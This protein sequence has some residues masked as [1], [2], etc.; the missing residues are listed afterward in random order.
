[1]G[2]PSINRFTF[3]TRLGGLIGLA[4]MAAA[5]F[6]LTACLDSTSPQQVP[7]PTVENALSVALAITTTK[8]AE[9]AT[10]SGAVKASNQTGFTGTGFADYKNNSS[11]Y[12]RWTVSVDQAGKYSLR[13][14]YANGGAISRPLAIKVNGTTV[15][16]S[17][18]FPATGAWTT[19]S[20]VSL[21]ANLV[22][23]NN[24]VQATAIGSSGANIDYLEVSGPVTSTAWRN[25]VLTWFTSYPDP[26]SEECLEFNGCTWAG[27]FAALDGKQP[28]SWVKAQNIIAVHEKDFSK[29]RLKTFRLKQG[30][31]TIDAKVYD[32]CSDSDCNGCC[33]KNAGSTGFLID[34]EKYTAERFGTREGIVDWT[35]LD[36]N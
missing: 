31:H 27:Q 6:V 33:T 4:A 20:T 11:D 24:T 5:P 32:M 28:E 29:Y 21:E 9:D 26:G 1:M 25:A 19:W 34:V 36:C 30:T 13:F 23:G 12:V 17:F 3:S 10:L 8:Q 15:N 16:S 18:G 7:D 35:C 22:S 2:I 14:R